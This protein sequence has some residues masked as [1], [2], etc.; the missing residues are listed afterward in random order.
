MAA[1]SRVTLASAGL[2]V[3]TLLQRC[4]DCCIVIADLVVDTNYRTY[5]LTYPRA[6]DGPVLSRLRA[7]VT[8]AM[9]VALI[10][11]SLIYRFFTVRRPRAALVFQIICPGNRFNCDRNA[12]S[13]SGCR[14]PTGALPT[15]VRFRPQ[16]SPSLPPCA[17]V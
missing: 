4:C 11:R 9:F 12:L 17:R 13:A 3:I 15:A 16:T 5:L 7:G 10:G 1:L 14:S 6:V 8:T 2:L